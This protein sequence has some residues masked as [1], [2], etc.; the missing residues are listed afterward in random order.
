MV[1]VKLGAIIKEVPEGALQ[2][3]LMAG[4]QVIETDTKK[5]TKKSS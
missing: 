1:K 4:W 2:W 5:T 3:Y